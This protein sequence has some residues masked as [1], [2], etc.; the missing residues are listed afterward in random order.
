MRISWIGKHPVISAVLGLFVLIGG[1]GAATGSGAHDK[2]AA[3]GR[4]TT[5]PTEPASVAEPEPSASATPT[6]TEISAVPADAEQASS[7]LA[8]TM[9]AALVVKGRGPKTGYDR[10]NFGIAWSDDNHDLLGHNG[11][12]TR[13][14]ILKRD[15]GAAVIKAGTNGC[16]VLSGTLADPYT[17]QD[18]TFE[19]GTN[20]SAEVQIDH[21]VALSDA[22]QKGA[23]GWGPLRRIDFAND[24]LNLLAVDASSNAAKGDGDAATWLP[25]NKPYRCSYVAR[26][27][28]VK[29]RY[30]LWV[31]TAER[32]A[33]SRVLSNCPAQT[34]PREPGAPRADRPVTPAVTATTPPPVVSVPAPVAAPPT[35]AADVYYANCA[36]ARAA[37]AA[38]IYR[39]SPGY[40]PALDRDGDG[41]ACE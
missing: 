14:D 29:A 32:A 37:G 22:W 3:V 23:Q 17:A 16:V 33:M 41:I 19:R 40:R 1:I 24:P 26:Q 7:A 27:I 34:A 10:K 12:D 13:N 25:P 21:V 11:C 8:T 6:P 31:T 20:T 2:P 35:T 5:S 15:L 38:P 39:G 36:A 4:P 9:L 28:A 30:G 18:I